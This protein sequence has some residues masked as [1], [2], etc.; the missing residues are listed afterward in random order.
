MVGSGGSFPGKTSILAGSE[1]L[2]A[3]SVT[4]SVTG[5]LPRCA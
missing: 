1:A 2:P 5:Y 4:V 3:L